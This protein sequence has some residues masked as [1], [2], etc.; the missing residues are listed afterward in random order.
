MFFVVRNDLIINNWLRV[1]SL[2]NYKLIL[3][4]VEN[5]YEGDVE[6]FIFLVVL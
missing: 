1:K 5:D 2:L 6:V 4:F 3:V